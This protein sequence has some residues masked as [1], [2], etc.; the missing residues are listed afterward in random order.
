MRAT[1]MTED[2]GRC[3]CVAL[4]AAGAGRAGRVGLGRA[5][6]DRPVRRC[7]ARR[8]L[9]GAGD[10]VPIWGFG[11]PATPGDCSDRHGRSL[12]GPLLGVTEGDAVTIN[13]TNALPAGAHRSRFEIPG[14]RL[15]ARA[16]RRRGRRHG[17]AHVHR[18][19]AGHV[20]LPERRRRRPPGGDGPRTAR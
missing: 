3:S 8:T 13:V 14:R 7:R 6:D 15:R 9:P 16:D 1:A 20:P 5:G 17:H 10:V 12:P 11:V 2:P 4:A 18:E 19:R